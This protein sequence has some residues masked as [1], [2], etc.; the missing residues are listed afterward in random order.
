MPDER[1]QPMHWWRSHRR[2]L[3]AEPG[4]VHR[5]GAARLPAHAAP[6]DQFPDHRRVPHRGR[7]CIGYDEVRRRE[8]QDAPAASGAPTTQLL[9]SSPLIP[10]LSDLPPAPSVAVLAFG[11]TSLAKDPDDCTAEEIISTLN[12]MRGVRV[13]SRSGSF[14][15]K[16]RAVATRE[17]GPLLNVRAVRDGSMRKAGDRSPP[18]LWATRPAH[19]RGKTPAPCATSPTNGRGISQICTRSIHL[20]SPPRVRSAQ[21]HYDVQPWTPRPV[22]PTRTPCESRDV[23]PAAPCAK[24][25]RRSR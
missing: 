6:A 14:Q 25:L 8:L 3:R 13:G 21:F 9:A 1:I 15:C 16:Q 2:R 20:M 17:I 24:S 11:D 18:A 12:A 4:R 23:R 10:P 22:L 7:H 5:G 19:G